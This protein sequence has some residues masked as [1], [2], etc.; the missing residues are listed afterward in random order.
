MAIGVSAFAGVFAAILAIPG[1][2]LISLMLGTSFMGAITAS[3]VGAAGI[4][5]AK[6][7]PTYLEMGLSPEIVH[8][9]IAISC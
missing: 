7:A 1:N 6:F 4:S 5:L 2:P 3:A 8:R 9:A